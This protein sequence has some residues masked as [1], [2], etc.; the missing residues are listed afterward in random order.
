MDE[1]LQVNNYINTFNLLDQI[2]KI[3]TI[4]VEI[5]QYELYSSNFVDW[6]KLETDTTGAQQFCISF[7]LLTVLMEYKRI[8]EKQIKRESFGKVLVMD[9]PF[10]EISEASLLKPMFELA[11][12][13]KVQII[14]YT[15][16]QNQAI[17]DSFGKIYLLKV[18]KSSQTN[19]EYVEGSVLKDSIEETAERS[20]FFAEQIRFIE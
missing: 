10:G 4:K 16:I 20:T 9:N 15:H 5:I 19:R 18:N 13:L 7:I 11:K 12:K 14:S 2:V 8:D 1:T 6:D 3:K 17:R